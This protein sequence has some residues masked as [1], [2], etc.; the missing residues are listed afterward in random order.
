MRVGTLATFNILKRN[1]EHSGTI[2]SDV[3]ENSDTKDGAL[4]AL[5]EDV[6]DLFFN[7]ASPVRL[8]QLHVIRTRKVRMTDLAEMTDATVQETSRHL[9]RMRDARIID[10]DSDGLYSL[11]S[12]GRMLLSIVPSL[13]VLSM[14]RNFFLTHDLTL[15]P[16]EFVDRIGALVN[17][18]FDGKAGLVQRRYENMISDALHYLWIMGDSVT[19]S[20]ERIGQLMPNQRASLRILFPDKG[21]ATPL[22]PREELANL[23]RTFHGPIEVRSLERTDVGIILNE[24][25]A[26]FIAPDLEG[27]LDYNVA[28]SGTDA[29]FHGWC[30]DLFV[31]YWS[32]ARRVVAYAHPVGDRE[33]EHLGP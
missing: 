20:G 7:L 4:P 31:H 30:R 11:T 23:R 28:F 26:R 6:T 24:E 8:Q 14:H 3:S 12:F 17:A 13:D 32:R 27:R 5:M 10:R 33:S 18:K 29:A 15:I 9:A 1:L 2:L 22:S 19:V 25:E 16:P 21:L